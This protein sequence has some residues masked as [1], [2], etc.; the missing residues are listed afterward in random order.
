M[1]MYVYIQF[2]EAGAQVSWNTF[3]SN[4]GLQSGELLDDLAAD[5]SAYPGPKEP[6]RPQRYLLGEV[7]FDKGFRAGKV[8]LVTVTPNPPQPRFSAR[9]KG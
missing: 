9:Y 8:R 1:I 3:S 5:I 4:N 7:D 2:N 6:Q